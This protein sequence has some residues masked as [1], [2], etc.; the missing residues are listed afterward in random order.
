MR[1]FLEE[2]I[3]SHGITLATCKRWGNDRKNALEAALLAS[4][5]GG[6]TTDDAIKAIKEILAEQLHAE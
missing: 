6:Y 4:C 5:L 2:Y 1:S 3:D